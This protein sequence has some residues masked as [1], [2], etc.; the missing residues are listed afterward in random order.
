M[1]QAGQIA[2]AGYDSRWLDK[3]PLWR[4]SVRML[5]MQ[6]QRPLKLTG[7]PF[8]VISYETMLSVR[9]TVTGYSLVGWLY[10][11]IFLCSVGRTFRFVVH[12]GARDS[13]MLQAGR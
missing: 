9:D 8:Y 5:I 6:A 2:D 7:G 3:N 10:R 11:P 12:V 13:A 1:L 4:H